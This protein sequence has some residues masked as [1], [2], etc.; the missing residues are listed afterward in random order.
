M[1]N[2]ELIRELDGDEY[3]HMAKS[4]ITNTFKHKQLFAQGF[5]AGG[6]PDGL[7][8]SP[9]AAWVNFARD[10]NDPRFPICCHIYKIGLNVDGANILHITADNFAEFDANTPSYWLNADLFDIDSRADGINH[11]KQSVDIDK[12][13]RRPGD[14]IYSVLLRGRVIFEDPEDAIANCEHYRDHADDIDLFKYKNWEFVSAVYDGV[15][16][17]AE[18]SLQKYLWY[19]S[20]DVVS[21]CIWNTAVVSITPIFVKHDDMWERINSLDGPPLLGN[22]IG[23]G[24]GADNPII[25]ESI[26]G[27]RD[28]DEV[29]KS[30][31]PAQVSECALTA[32]GTGTCVSDATVAEIGQVIGSAGMPKKAIMDDAKSKLGCETEKCVL[33]KLQDK[34]GMDVV[35]REIN[36]NIKVKGP[37]NTELLSNVHIDNTMKQWGRTWTKFFPY[38][39]NMRN[40]A[41]YSFDRGET[42]AKPDTLATITFSD[43]AAKGIKCCGCVIN[44]DV[45][46][47]EGTH[48]MALF[49]DTRTKLT[50]EFFN[51]SGNAPAPEWVNWMQKTKNCMEELYPGKPVTMLNVSSIAHQRSKSECGLY[52]LFYIWA[53]LHEVPPEYFMTHEVGDEFMFEFRQHLFADSGPTVGKPFDWETYKKNVKIEWEIGGEN[54][55][56]V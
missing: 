12:L 13:V 46:Q 24:N 20:L 26:T 43:L 11:V 31:L 37:T 25:G 55:V 1:T 53:R 41:S 14:T 15:I 47:G 44:K 22:I 16:F 3:Y 50:V 7:W 5:N 35:K 48:W 38:N 17:H 6:R 9:G 56:R 8:I 34:L 45:Y 19:K 52:S 54:N 28:K 23:A 30:L 18:P 40:Y 42:V 36:Q 49:A 10:V 29:L 39:F 51:S 2:E 33:N 32:D 4:E 27:G 21:G